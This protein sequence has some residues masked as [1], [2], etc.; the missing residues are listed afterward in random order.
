MGNIRVDLLDP[1]TGNKTGDYPI[2]SVPQVTRRQALDRIG[3]WGFPFSVADPVLPD[4]ENKDYRVF[5]EHNGQVH[6]L[7]ECSY[8]SHNIDAS[9]RQV[10]VEAAGRLRDLSRVSVTQKSFDGATDDVNDVITWLVGLLTGWSEG[11]VDTV[12]KAAPLDFWYENVYQSVDLLARTF[13]LHFREG[14]T[15]KTLDFGA[16]GAS[17]GV[18]AVGGDELQF[19]PSFHQNND[20]VALAAVKVSYKG[21]Q[22]VN[23]LIPFGGAVGVATIDLSEVTAT[24]P[25][26][27]V[28]TD[29][30]PDGG[31]YYYIEDT[32]S[33]TTYGLTTRRFLRKDLRPISNSPLSREFAAN[34]LYE[35]ALASLLNLKDRQTVYELSVTGW[36]PNSVQVGDKIS[37]LYRGVAQTRQGQ[38]VWLDISDS[39]K[40]KEFYVLEIAETFGDGV[41]ATLKINENAVHE[42]TVEELLANAINSFEQAQVHVQPTISRYTVGPYTKRVSQSPAVSA[43]FSFKLGLET[44]NVFY[45]KLLI[46]GEPLKSSIESVAGSSTTTPSGGGTTSQSAAAHNHDSVEINRILVSA[47][48]S[49][50]KQ[51]YFHQNDEDIVF[52]SNDSGPSTHTKTSTSDNVHSHTVPNHDH[53]F[54]PNIS[55]TYGIFEDTVRPD[56]LTIKL[57]GSTIASGVTLSSPDYDYELDITSNILAASTLQQEHKIT[58]ECGDERGEIQFQAQVLAVIQPIAVT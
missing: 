53:T 57:N 19:E 45:V 34:V 28:V 20:V 37:V 33:Q 11:S 3:K 55:T 48:N 26:Y 25:G 4:A 7:G 43:E 50:H 47:I 12:A 17:S 23:R 39:G 29:T 15:A 1:L 38:Q 31:N 51:L 27:P 56:D 42:E 10:N 40:G 30:L 41:T 46:K 6:N 18:L 21:D 14:S 22:V 49:N 52:P 9:G 5:W 54:T 58:I 16:F 35:A 13:G 44:L 24:Q 8:L 2:V 32:A 36:V